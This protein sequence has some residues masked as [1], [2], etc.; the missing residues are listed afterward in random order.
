MSMIV[1]P[2]EINIDTVMQ[3]MKRWNMA[4]CRL[5]SA[6]PGTAKHAATEAVIM[7]VEITLN[8]S[9]VSLCR[10]VTEILSVPTDCGPF[11]PIHVSDCVRTT[12]FLRFRVYDLKMQGMSRG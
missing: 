4:L 8:D 9:T 1:A 12:V 10:S 2:V 6:S 3:K 7:S 11:A 5:S